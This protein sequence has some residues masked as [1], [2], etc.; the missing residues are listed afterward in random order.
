MTENSGNIDE[1]DEHGNTA[2]LLEKAFQ[3]R[4]EEVIRLV[5]EGVDINAE[6]EKCSPKFRP[7]FL[8]FYR[9]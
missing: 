1:K 9:L 6:N 7:L 5:T 3:G 4:T 8:I 2:L